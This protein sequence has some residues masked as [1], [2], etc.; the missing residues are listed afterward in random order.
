MEAPNNTNNYP[1]IEYYVFKVTKATYTTYAIYDVN[2]G[3]D[4]EEG[5][6]RILKLHPEYTFLGL[7]RLALT[8]NPKS[9][10]FEF[11]KSMHALEVI[12]QL[13]PL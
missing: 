13:Y 11:N 2:K 4:K 12:K 5:K 6:Q 7:Q 9:F 8:A 10:C 1:T 3:K